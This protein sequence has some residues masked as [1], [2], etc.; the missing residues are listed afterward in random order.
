MTGARQRYVVLSDTST[1]G[2]M[3]GIMRS[4][5]LLG[6]NG[7]ML[8]VALGWL[9]ARGPSAAVFVVLALALLGVACAAHSLRTRF[10]QRRPWPR[11]VV[12]GHIGVNDPGGPSL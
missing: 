12:F 2:G 7:T 8:I 9:I 6:A 4:T 10:R 1:T 11:V 5:L 3:V